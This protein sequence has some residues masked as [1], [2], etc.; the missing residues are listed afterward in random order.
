M[1]I[2][3]AIFGTRVSPRF[4]F[5][6][7][8][9]LVEITDGE[10][11]GRREIPAEGWEGLERIE[12]LAESAVEAVICGSI[13]RFSL[14]QLEMRGIKVYSWITGEAEDALSSFQKGQLESGFMMA[15]GGRCCGRWRFRQGQGQ[16]QG[17]GRGRG[18]GRRSS[19][20]A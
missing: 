20:G 17:Q 14:R 16:G 12:K 18:R 4:D 10:I 13:D 8:F 11:V 19:P 6:P 1:K 2:A 9:M 5:A 7:G 3:I 15:Q